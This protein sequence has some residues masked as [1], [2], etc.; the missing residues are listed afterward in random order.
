MYAYNDV[1]NM[2]ETTKWLENAYI[3]DCFASHCAW[4]YEPRWDCSAYDNEHDECDLRMYYLSEPGI[5]EQEKTLIEIK[6]GLPTVIV[7]N[8]MQYLG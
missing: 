2:L 8:I 1:I 7:D 3:E 4:C 6:P 5:V